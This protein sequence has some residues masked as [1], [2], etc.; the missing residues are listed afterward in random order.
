MVILR[1]GLII[2]EPA[3]VV[4]E[5]DHLYLLGNHSDGRYYK[6]HLMPIP[7]INPK[8]IKEVDDGGYLYL[9]EWK[10]P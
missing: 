1:F 6:D 10:R 2:Q 3:S 5:P 8:D 9:D 4:A 7:G